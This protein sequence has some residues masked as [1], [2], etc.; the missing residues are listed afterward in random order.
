MTELRTIS[1]S[2]INVF[3]KCSR[4]YYYKYVL[5][6]ED[7]PEDSKNTAA[8]M[9]TALHKAIE[10]H[11]KDFANPLSTFQE[12]MRNTLTE[13][14]S[15][16]LTIKGAEYFTKGMKDGQSILKTFDWNRW[17]PKELEYEFTL[18]FPNAENPI[19]MITGLIDL[20]DIH[21]TIADHKSSKTAPNQDELDN[22]PQFLIYAWAYKQIWGA[23]PNKVIWNHL[24]TGKLYTANIAHNFEFK[25]AQLT[26]D[27]EAM[28]QAN[29]FQRKEMDSFCRNVCSFYTQ[30]YGETAPKTVSVDELASAIDD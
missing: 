13:W 29:A 20:I 4:Q 22:N 10:A 9:G 2:R 30:C 24:R 26:L 5:P 27:I 18:P 21:G 8:L 19:V 15:T 16:G 3:R 1:A 12:V 11:Y 23:L 25:L 6:R 7:R 14:E 17:K 28:L